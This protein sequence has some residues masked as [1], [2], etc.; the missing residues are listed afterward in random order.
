LQS[1][2][3]YTIGQIGSGWG[4]PIGIAVDDNSNV[5]IADPEMGGL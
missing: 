2:G 1:D 4:Y 3:S 5:Y